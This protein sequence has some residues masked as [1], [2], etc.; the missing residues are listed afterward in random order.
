MQ[1]GVLLAN[2]ARVVA[3]ASIVRSHLLQ[4]HTLRLSKIERES[5]TAALYEFIT[6]ERCTLLLGRVDERAASLL[7][8]QEKEIQW[9]ENNWTKQGEAIRAIQKAKADLDN[10]VALI[11]GGSTEDDAA[12]TEVS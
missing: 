7:K 10:E 2:P 6:S 1:D 5:K 8:R 11:I 4:L 3:V 9:H 12:M